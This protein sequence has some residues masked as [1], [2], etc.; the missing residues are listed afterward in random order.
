[1]YYSIP[2]RAKFFARLLSFWLLTT[3]LSAPFF[4]RADFYLSGYLQG[5]GAIATKEPHQT[6]RMDS[7]EVTIQLRPNSYVVD[8]VFKLFNE[9]EETTEWVGFPLL[10]RSFSTPVPMH[11]I[12]SNDGSSPKWLNLPIITGQKDYIYPAYKSNDSGET[13]SE[14]VGK[15][16]GLPMQSSPKV[17]SNFPLMIKQASVNGDPVFFIQLWDEPRIKWCYRNVPV[18]WRRHDSIER[19]IRRIKWVAA[20]IRFPGYISTTIRVVYERSYS[21]NGTKERNVIEYLYGAAGNWKGS[22]HNVT[23]CIDKSQHDELSM[24]LVWFIR[25]EKACGLWR[26]NLKPVCLRNKDCQVYQINRCEPHEEDYLQIVSDEG[27]FRPRND[28]TFL[29]PEEIDV[30]PLLPF[31]PCEP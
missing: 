19:M 9:G 30:G 4:A 28:G 23:F 15:W 25:I 24:M 14:W 6:I 20:V 10:I 27:E 7:M 22:I 17:C 29:K 13:I 3:T 2:D 18:S 26:P 8:S 21:G 31:A 1:M 12:I 5:A 11:A 16:I